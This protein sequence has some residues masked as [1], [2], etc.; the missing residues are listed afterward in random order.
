[1]AV[2]DIFKVIKCHLAPNLVFEVPTRFDALLLLIFKLLLK[3]AKI[4]SNLNQVFAF[5]TLPFMTFKGNVAFL[6][7]SGAL[8][9]VF[10]DNIADSRHAF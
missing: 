7:V 9:I 5:I 10:L 4:I 2:R 3:L 1:M 8:S 6:I